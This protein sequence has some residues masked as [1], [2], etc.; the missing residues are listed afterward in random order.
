MSYCD[1]CIHC[2][3]CG[4]EG[5]FEEALGFCAEK[6]K[7]PYKVLKDIKVEIETDLSWFCFDEY[8]NKK[9]DW[10]QL[11]KVFDKYIG[12]ENIDEVSN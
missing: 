4:E 6:I 1:D 12:K 3:V 9:W 5:A 2:N 10:K 11:E 8:G 7:E